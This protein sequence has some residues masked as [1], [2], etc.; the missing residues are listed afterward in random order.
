MVRLSCE[1]GSWEVRGD[2]VVFL[3]YKSEGGYD[4][5][6]GTRVGRTRRTGTDIYI[7][8]CIS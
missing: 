2:W 4:P 7:S 1:F 8:L 3:V 6:T 5:F